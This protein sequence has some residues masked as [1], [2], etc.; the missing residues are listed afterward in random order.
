MFFAAVMSAKVTLAT[1]RSAL[2]AIQSLERSSG[3]D[4]W[5]AMNSGWIR[6]PEAEMREYVEQVWPHIVSH[7]LK[8]V[9][10]SLTVPTDSP[11]GPEQSNLD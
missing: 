2:A 9:G 7:C 11:F 8:L 6:H 4:S 1:A 3:T 5:F 10:R